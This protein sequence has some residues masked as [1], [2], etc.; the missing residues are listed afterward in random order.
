MCYVVDKKGYAKISI[1]KHV[2]EVMHNDYS[3]SARSIFVVVILYHAK[4]IPEKK[5]PTT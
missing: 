3:F 4:A 5:Q 1:V 2:N